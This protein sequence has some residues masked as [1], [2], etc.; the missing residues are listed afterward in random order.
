M[1]FRFK[2]LIFVE[3]AIFDCFSQVS[4]AAEVGDYLALVSVS[5]PD[6][7][8]NSQINVTL[9]GGDGRYLCFFYRRLILKCIF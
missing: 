5:D 2:E 3:K 8:E 1:A 6:L 9:T 4:E 7:S